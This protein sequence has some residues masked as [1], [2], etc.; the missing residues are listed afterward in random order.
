MCSLCQTQDRRKVQR[1]WSLREWICGGCRLTKG[2]TRGGIDIEY[3]AGMAILVKNRTHLG[4]T[5][6]QF[7]W[8]RSYRPDKHDCFSDSD[9]AGFMAELMAFGSPEQA[10]S[11]IERRKR[12]TV[13]L[14]NHIRRT[15][16][17]LNS[18]KWETRNELGRVRVKAITN[19]IKDMGYPADEASSVAKKFWV[20]KVLTDRDWRKIQHEVMRRLCDLR[21]PRIA[22]DSQ[23]FVA[24]RELVAQGY[25]DYKRTLAPREWLALPSHETICLFPPIIEKLIEP[26]SVQLS[27]ADFMEPIRSIQDKVQEW[28]RDQERDITKQV[29]NRLDHLRT[30]LH[31]VLPSYAVEDLLFK[32]DFQRFEE[33]YRNLAIAQIAC[34]QCYPQRVCTTATVAMRHLNNISSCCKM[35]SQLAENYGSRSFNI[36]FSDA[37]VSLVQLSGLNI[38]TTTADEMDERGDFFRCLT[39][40][41]GDKELGRRWCVWTWRDCVKYHD[42]NQHPDG[43]RFEILAGEDIREDD[44]KCWTC[45]HCNAHIESLVTRSAVREHL[46][47]A[48]WISNPRVPVD[49]AFAG[50]Y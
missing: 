35:R 31:R 37:A 33:H 30:V 14:R 3:S 32:T 50:R 13:D 6:I 9:I 43:S 29:F 34:M 18:E 36:E 44:R 23:P 40:A 8:S 20:C 45:C 2:I 26:D 46:K 49:F 10:S 24:R 41:E 22:D 1:N 7:V 11:F 48:H 5:A 12:D 47:E 28:I 17:W 21:R 27:K 16:N 19:R 39:C 4:D 42:F 38:M 25:L 15:V